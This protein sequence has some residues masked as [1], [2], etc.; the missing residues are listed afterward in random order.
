MSSNNIISDQLPSPQISLS[1]HSKFASDTIQKIKSN[2]AL[3]LAIIPL[4]EKIFEACAYCFSSPQTTKIT[5]IVKNGV[6]D[7]LGIHSLFQYTKYFRNAFSKETLDK[8]KLKLSISE[9][10][11]RLLKNELDP[12]KR[13]NIVITRTTT[14]FNQVMGDKKCKTEDEILNAIKTAMHHHY[15]S[16]EHIT[17][18]EFN[19][20]I[21]IEKKKRSVLKV[22]SMAC[23]TLCASGKLLS[24]LKKWNILDLGKE[25]L[26]IGSQS[27]VFMFILNTGTETILGVISSA[28]ILLAIGDAAK[29]IT[30]HLICYRRSE[31]KEKKDEAYHRL[32]DSLF[33]L[34]T[35]VTN[36]AYALAPLAFA[37]NPPVVIGLAIVA[38]ATGIGVMLIRHRLNKR[39]DTLQLTIK[40]KPQQRHAFAVNDKRQHRK[41]LSDEESNQ[42]RKKTKKNRFP[43]ETP[44]ASSNGSASSLSAASKSSIK[45][46]NNRRLSRRKKAHPRLIRPS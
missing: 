6:F 17:D 15:G 16:I 37:L 14:I 42:E 26:K 8:E 21:I 29:Q 5:A 24:S 38:K 1:N 31:I 43:E 45:E 3:I 40:S 46:T 34:L 22:L 7:A 32:I 20:N 12:I 41:V 25:A 30:T 27:S 11:N 35:H 19:N 10:V 23:F 39:N 2:S 18:A 4:A 36:L 9:V 33:D 44:R 28:G 13:K